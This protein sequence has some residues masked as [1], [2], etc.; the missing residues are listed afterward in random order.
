MIQLIFC[1]IHIM[2]QNDL[3]LFG[4]ATQHPNSLKRLFRLVD[5]AVNATNLTFRILPRRNTNFPCKDPPVMASISS[6]IDP[7]PRSGSSQYVR[8]PLKM[9]RRI[10]EVEAT[11]LEKVDGVR[12]VS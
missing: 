1:P 2:R 8:V 9:A 7:F 5:I 4:G 12:E 10:N 11:I 6:Q 3:H